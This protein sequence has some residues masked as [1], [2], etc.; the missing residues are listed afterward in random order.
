MSCK[1]EEVIIEP[2]P[3]YDEQVATEVMAEFIDD[4]IEKL[5]LNQLFSFYD[6]YLSSGGRIETDIRAIPN[7]YA[8]RIDCA[9]ITIN[10]SENTIT[11]DFGSGCS[12]QNGILRAGKIIATFS[13]L[14]NGVTQEIIIRLED[15]ELENIE[16]KGLRTITNNTEADF[17]YSDLNV[18]VSSGTLTFSDD[19]NYAYSSER[20]VSNFVFRVDGYPE[21]YSF[22]VSIIKT[23]RNRSFQ[24][25]SVATE[26]VITYSSDCFDSGTG[27][28]IAGTLDLDV[29]GLEK[30][31]IFST[32]ECASNVEVVF[33]S[34]E[35]FLMDLSGLGINN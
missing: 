35:V 8:G 11:I 24:S 28:A 17:A 21:S 16:V 22:G 19:T 9:S 23:G 30:R 3:F 25:F 12:A 13:E 14:N 27:Q 29:N 7:P 5:V 4:D 20:S 32:S 18:T 2:E 26:D 33:P 1:Q 15:Y 6:Q 10:E 31:I 34:G